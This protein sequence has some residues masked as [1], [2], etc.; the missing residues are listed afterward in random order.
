MKTALNA[1]IQIII[2]KYFVARRRCPPSTKRRGRADMNECATI[3]SNTI[4]ESTSML[5][6]FVFTE[7]RVEVQDII[8]VFNSQEVHLQC[9]QLLPSC[10]GLM[11]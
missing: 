1:D 4:V 2:T 3:M 10:D 5:L 6:I 9:Y 7:N 8:K 11:N